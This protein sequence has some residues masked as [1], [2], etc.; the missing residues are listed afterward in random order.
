MSSPSRVLVVFGT[1]TFARTAGDAPSRL[2]KRETLCLAALALAGRPGFAR[3][4][5]QALFWPDAEAQA[6]RNACKQLVF[7]LRRR[8]GRDAVVCTPTCIRLD[9]D[10]VQCDTDAFADAVRRRDAVAALAVSREPLLD[11]LHAWSLLELDQWLDAQRARV[12]RLRN[13]ML[14]LAGDEALRRLLA[15]KARVPGMKHYDLAIEASEILRVFIE[16]AHALPIRYQTTREFLTLAAESAHLSV[17]QRQILAQFLGFCDLA[18]FARQPATQAEM[19]QSV[20]TAIQ[21]VQSAARAAHPTLTA[22]PGGV[23]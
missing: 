17:P 15:L 13:D 18:K 14:M 11:G 21:F 12:A 16:G 5:L 20:E 1:L 7:K 22:Q 3:E 2:S 4:K 8:T 10:R 9:F 6:A 19:V 23:A